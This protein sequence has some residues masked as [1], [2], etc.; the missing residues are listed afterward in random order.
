MRKLFQDVHALIRFIVARFI[1]DRCADTAASLTFTTLLALV[2]MITIALTMFSAFPVFED[3]SLQ[4]KAF[5]LKNLLPENAGAI[6]QYMQ[7]FS[8]SAARLTAVGIVFLTVTAMLM[9]LT[10]DEAF[11]VIWR[12]TQPRP[13]LKRLVVYWA[14]LT[15]APLL[16]GASLSL[17][18]WMVG[19]SMGHAKLVSSFGVAVLKTLPIVFTTLAFTL[20]FRVVPN[21]HVPWSHALIGALLA[22]VVFEIMIRVFGYFIIHFT[23]YTL[24]YGAFASVPIFLMWIYSSWFTILFGAVIA[25]SLSH[26][27]TPHSHYLAPAAQLLDALRMLRSMANGL[28]EGK[29]MTLSELSQSLHLSFDSLEN[30]LEKLMSGDIV[31]KAEGS[32]WLLIRDMNHVRATELVHLFVLDR[33]SLHGIPADD[34]LRQWLEVYI[35]QLDQRTDITL[36]E[37]FAR[38]V[39]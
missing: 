34:P 6:T 18:S 16:I 12:V 31:R 1:Q 33:G 8:D 25:A 3:F 36:Q 7:Q 13:L 28:Q 21:R 22:G 11:N 23:T 17:T 10:I 14:V 20:L 30:I 24:V 4:T 37:L 9:M 39:A 27:R 5:L 35:E 29:L 15:V 2:P 26:W 38:Q 32:G 19:L